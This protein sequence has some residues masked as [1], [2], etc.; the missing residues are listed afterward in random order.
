MILQFIKFCVVG[1]SGLVVDFATTYLCKEKLRLNKYLSNSIG[2]IVAA[3][4]NYLLNR[5]WTFH[6]KDPEVAQQY[7]QFIGIAAIGLILNNLIIYLLNDKA[8]LNF[9][10]SKLIAIGI[11]TLWNFFMNYFFT[12]TA[13]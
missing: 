7:I 1:G 5:I 12:F 2:F 11:V 6:S 13:S 3:S 10:L 8:K 4:T 9:Y